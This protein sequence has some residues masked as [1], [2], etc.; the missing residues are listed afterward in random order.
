MQLS[1]CCT[2][3]LYGPTEQFSF[4][5]SES[6]IMSS[7]PLVPT[8]HAQTSCPT[9]PAPPWLSTNKPLLLVFVKTMQISHQSQGMY[10]VS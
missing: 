7:G 3:S 10:K 4:T 2:E 9:K 1:K 5:A 6:Y 8:Q